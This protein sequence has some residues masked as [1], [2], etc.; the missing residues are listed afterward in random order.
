MIHKTNVDK[1]GGLE[2][3]VRVIVEEKPTTDVRQ[4]A[5]RIADWLVSSN[6]NFMFRLKSKL[7]DVGLS[8]QNYLLLEDL[9]SSGPFIMKEIAEKLD[10]TVAA[11]T[12]TI[13]RLTDQSY[14]RRIPFKN[15][16]RKV[17]VEITDTGRNTLESIHVTIQNQ[18][19]SAIMA[20]SSGDSEEASNICH[21]LKEL[22]SLL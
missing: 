10:V 4:S 15:D 8:Y 2:E 22:V 18:I 1:Q 6:R 21:D 11:A 5:A 7:N 12:G 9:S 19:A 16:R 3:E 13:D 20:E 17:A 14:T